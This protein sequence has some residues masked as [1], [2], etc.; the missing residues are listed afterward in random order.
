[1]TNR[2]KSRLDDLLVIRGFAT[3]RSQAR[4]SIMAGLVFRGETRLDKPGQRVESNINLMIRGRPHPWASRG[5]IK[6]AHALDHFKIEPR[7]AIC[8]DIG[9]SAGGFTDV[10]LTRGAIKVYAVDSGYGQ[11]D[12]R[13]RNDPRVIV[14]ER[15]NAR[16]LDPNQVPERVGLI[17]CDASFISLTKVLPAPLQRAHPGAKL[18][19]LIKP[20]FEAERHHVGK[21]GVVRDP[22]VH[23]N[24]CQKIE[25][26]LGTQQSWTVLGIERSPITGPKGNVE[27]LIAAQLSSR[28]PPFDLPDQTGCPKT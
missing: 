3:S 21:G 15:V 14:R 13:L 12:W 16:Y 22:V 7:G 4:A 6:L 23:T 28:V 1:M 26:W 27:F 5:G 19:A 18:I 24:V 11:L 2:D 25:A 8:L 20:Q 10:L 9:A 17:A